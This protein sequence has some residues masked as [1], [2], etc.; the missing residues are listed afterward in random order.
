MERLN[1]LPE[2]LAMT[3][4]KRLMLQLDRQLIPTFIRVVG[5]LFLLVVLIAFSQGWAAHRYGVKTERLKD[6]AGMIQQEL[7][8]VETLVIQLNQKE[9]ALLQQIDWQAQRLRYLESYQDRS[10]RWA[11]ILQA[12]K[13]SLPYGLWLTELEG[14]ANRFLRMNGGA[15][16]E[17][18]VIQFMAELKQQPRFRDVAF[19]FTKKAKI[20]QTEIVQYEVTC[21]VVPLGGQGR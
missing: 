5:G 2:D 19:N 10:D 4:V 15:F 16:E 13:R 7:K 6:R 9:Q 18:L 12:V 21:R 3:P 20:G 8:L 11:S 14:D 1:L 17:D